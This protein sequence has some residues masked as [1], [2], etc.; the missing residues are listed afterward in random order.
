MITANIY[1]DTAVTGYAAGD[2]LTVVSQTGT[3]TWTADSVTGDITFDF[4]DQC[5]DATATI[6]IES[7]CCTDTFIVSYVSPCEPCEFEHFGLI[8]NG[9]INPDVAT[10]ASNA[11]AVQAQ[12]LIYDDNL[13]AAPLGGTAYWRSYPGFDTFPMTPRGHEFQFTQE[14]FPADITSLQFDGVWKNDSN[15]TQLVIIE[16]ID[17]A[18][19]VTQTIDVTADF[20]SAPASSGA[21]GITIDVPITIGSSIKGFRILQGSATAM[22]PSWIRIAEIS[23]VGTACQGVNPCSNF[24]YLSP[25][26]ADCDGVNPVIVS[27]INGAT[28]TGAGG[29]NWDPATVTMVV[30]SSTGNGVVTIN[31][32]TNGAWSYAPDPTD[33]DVEVTVLFTDPSG[34]EARIVTQ[35]VCAPETTDCETWKVACPNLDMSFDYDCGLGAPEISMDFSDNLVNGATTIHEQRLLAMFSWLQEIE[36]EFSV[37]PCELVIEETFPAQDNHTLK[38]TWSWTHPGP[39]GLIEVCDSSGNLTESIV[40]TGS[41]TAQYEIDL[42]YSIDS[43]A[44]ISTTGSLNLTD[45]ATL[46]ANPTVGTSGNC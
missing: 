31:D 5:E 34:C 1:S 8:D 26:M 6:R 16:L 25:Q 13:V 17:N 29:S 40:F 14:I 7:E 24:G 12:D 37:T 38:V 23:P 27:N 18:G 35:I 45:T 20:D 28:G 30:E 4:V 42:R 10:G 21:T 43:V 3:G 22:T 19:N 33:T 36:P 9:N 2:T 32:P 11:E 46:I 15:S 39:S 44:M 41:C